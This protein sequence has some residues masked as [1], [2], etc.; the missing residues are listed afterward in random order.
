[1]LLSL[2]PLTDLDIPQVFPLESRRSHLKIMAESLF[3]KWNVP[4]LAFVNS[5]LLD[6]FASGRQTGLALQSGN[7]TRAV[8]VFEGKVLEQHALGLAIGGMR[9][10]A[11][12]RESLVARGYSFNSPYADD[13]LVR[14]IKE[15]LME[16]RE[17]PL[18]IE[19]SAE[20]EE[21]YEKEY[22]LPDGQ[23]I[24][25]KQEVPRIGESFFQPEILGSSDHDE[26]S[27]RP[28]VHM[29]VHD[30]ITKC[31]ENMRNDLFG[32][33]VISGGSI[34]FPGFSKRLE[35]ELN[36]LTRRDCEVKVSSDGARKY[37]TFL[38]GCLYATASLS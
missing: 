28:G 15:Q 32:N 36:A 4:S 17:S 5:A 29:L 3:E 7:Y 33:I 14:D 24:T 26:A 30:S 34:L 2:P 16:I 1:M 8:P 22:E 18:A 13:P 35:L 25:I 10:D 37:Q 12:T 21:F 20:F 9:L 6:L 23:T 19:N 11:F 27:G 31:D 38:G